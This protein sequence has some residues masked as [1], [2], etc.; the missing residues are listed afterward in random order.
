[1]AAT[2]DEIA[3]I[4][5]LLTQYGALRT[6]ELARHLRDRGMD[7]PDS[8][9]RWNLLEMD[10]PARQ[11]V[12]DRWVWLP[13][14][15]AGRVF[16]HRVSAVE[17]THDMLNHSP[18]LSPITAL[19]QHADY[20]N[21]AD[22]S[23]ANIV[24]AGYDDQL[25]EE[26]GIPPEAIDPVAVL[27]LAPGTLA[28]LTVADGDTVGL[29]LTA[30][31]L[32]LERVDVIAEHTAGA[33]LAATLDA[34][35]PT[36]VD[37]AVWT[38]CVAD[39]ALFT[40]PILPLSEIVD[41][42]GLARRGDSIAPSG[43]DFGRWQF[44]RRCELL[45]ERHGIDVDDALVLTT[46]LELYD[47]TWRILAEADDADDAD[48]DAPDE[49]DESPTLQ[50]ADHSDD[51]TGELGAQLA[52]P[53]LAQLLVAETV[54]SDHGGA[55]ALGLLAEM[56]EPKVPRAARVAWRWLR[57]V[58]L[59]RLGDTEE[60]ER[61]LLAAES[62]DPDWPLPLIDLA[63]F[64]SDRGDV[65]RGLALLRRAGDLDHP[66]VALLQAHRVGPRNDLGRNEPCWCGSGRKYKKCHLGREQLALAQRVNWLYEKAAH[67]VYA[68]GWRE[69]LAEVGYER[70]R[71]THDLFEAVDAGMADD[72]VMDVVL[73]EG[74]AFAEFLEVRGS[75]LPDDERLLAEQWLLV[76]R[77]LFD[78][79]DVKPGVS[80]TVRDVRSGDT[81]DVVSRTASRHL[82]SGQLI[83]ARVVPAGDDSVQFFGGIEPIALHERDSLIELLDAEP[84]PVELMDAL[85]R[86]FAPATL[87]NTEGDPLAICQATV[88]LGDPERVEA[89]LDEAY[90]RAHD[91][92]TPRW[93]EHVTTHGMPRIRAALVREGDTLRVETNSAER[94]D[95][96][97]ATLIRVDP[98]MRVVDDSRRPIRDAREAAEL[99]AEMG[100]PERALDPEDPAVAEALGEFIREYETK[101]LD[102]QIPALDG[103]TPR[104]AADDPTR[105]G[106]LI[107]LL[108]SFPADDGTAGRMSPERLRVALGLE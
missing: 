18:D 50:P 82:K 86:R 70:Y 75:L 65:E 71:H 13:A 52:D 41:D 1:M 17:C 69:L 101:W 20:Q 89:A 85:S 22:G 21:L 95:R 38:A 93:H 68:A 23:A 102:E 79:E 57:A 46:L 73:F 19:C 60:A 29:R 53:L 108:D 66:L 55:A 106:D 100:P 76:E 94:M 7:D 59:E 96:V 97:L 2:F 12:D 104:Q 26:R 80:V 34:D 32:V 36:Y 64:A 5:E 9:I 105:R 74:G 92:E 78:V 27:L 84:D 43:F 11:L 31:G 67:H 81:H 28:K 99:A 48:A 47:Q 24:V 91:D 33:R 42:H 8:T 14:V 88:R 107:K 87:T 30:E 72:L 6:D 25:I 98:A 39:A 10:C 56:M 49:A 4:A 35:E 37:A 58:A 3:T 16:T 40:D 77:S 90:D 15:L 54:G 51:V 61:E 63:R 103:H 44:E 62:M 45:A 83:C